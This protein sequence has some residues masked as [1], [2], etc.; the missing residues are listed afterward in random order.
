[1]NTEKLTFDPSLYEYIEL[2]DFLW[3][4]AALPLVHQIVF[5]DYELLCNI[6]V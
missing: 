3:A 6:P 4:W 2:S 5:R 1:M